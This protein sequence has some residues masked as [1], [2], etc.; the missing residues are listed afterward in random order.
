[1]P[2][3]EARVSGVRRRILVTEPKR[4]RRARF[5]VSEMPGMSSRMLSPTRRFM[6][7]WW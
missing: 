5:L 6:R 3:T 2:G 1:M 7:S 4:A